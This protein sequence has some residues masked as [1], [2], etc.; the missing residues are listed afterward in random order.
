MRRSEQYQKRAESQS[1]A[2]SLSSS[3]AKHQVSSDA[4]P[5]GCAAALVKF[6]A[7]ATAKKYRRCSSSTAQFYHAEKAWRHIKHDIGISD[8]GSSD[9][10]LG[11]AKATVKSQ[12]GLNKLSVGRIY[13]WGPAEE[14]SSRIKGESKIL[15]RAD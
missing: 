2:N 12:L 3:D 14:A 5:R 1:A 9:A 6:N 15:S 7:S 13:G 10:R 8:R 4:A 11:S